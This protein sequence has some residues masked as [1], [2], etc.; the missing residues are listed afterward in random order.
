[1]DD[2]AEDQSYK[3]RRK[4]SS[5]VLDLWQAG[6]ER[7]GPWVGC[8]GGNERGGSFNELSLTSDGRHSRGAG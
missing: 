1:M 2:S 7:I 8:V 6:A 4:S 5:H 3:D